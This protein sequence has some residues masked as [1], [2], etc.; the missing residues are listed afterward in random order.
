MFF[1]FERVIHWHHHHETHGKHPGYVHPVAY[2]NLIG[3]GI[4][5]FF[6]GAV[7]AVAFL[8]NPSLGLATTLAVVFHEIPQELGDFTIL[9]HG[10]FSRGK[11]L[12]FNFLSALTAFVGAMAAFLFSQFITQYSA[13]FLAFAAGGFIYIAVADLIP[14]LHREKNLAKSIMQAG[15]IVFGALV[16]GFA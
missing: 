1:L 14:E 6:D 8:T 3:D 7:I 15:L 13:Y 11:A 12:F 5:N 2:M 4:H 9:V 16:I 10:G